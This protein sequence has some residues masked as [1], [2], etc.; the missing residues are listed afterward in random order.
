MSLVLFFGYLAGFL[1][2]VSLVPQVIKMWRRKS[3]DDFSLAMLLI[4]CAGIACWT[5]YGFL[6]SAK[7]VIFWNFGTLLLAGSILLMK[8]K[9]TQKSDQKPKK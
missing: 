4:W 7:P 3:A 5:I 1:T 9:F 6:I 8:F 2:T